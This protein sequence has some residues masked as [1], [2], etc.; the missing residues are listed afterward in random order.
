MV[1]NEGAASPS[2][3]EGG[4]GVS[5][6]GD[7]SG[8]P[9]NVSSPGAGP[10]A[11]QNPPA[12]SLEEPAPAVD[13]DASEESGAGPYRVTA[14]DLGR[15]AVGAVTVV[16]A[17][18]GLVLGIRA[19]LYAGREDQRAEKAEQ[20]AAAEE[21]RSKEDREKAY[22][23][24]VDFYRMGSGVIV[25][26]GSS[27]VMTMRLTLPANKVSWDLDLLQPCK[28]I[29]VQNKA[30]LHS[31]AVEQPSVSLAEGDLAQLRLEFM[32][33]ES[34]AWIRHSGGALAR[35]DA[36]VPSRR[37]NLVSSE[38]WNVSAQDSPQCDGS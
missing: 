18:V 13:P 4:A 22:A 34:K 11:A 19:E 36:W 20:R 16:A 32:D 35:M 38:E 5:G 25:V 37:P 27:R 23:N 29:A 2:E 8:T 28:Q 7:G 3:S 31:M 24:L 14:L 12:P 9:E 26:N 30:L 10:V 6:G 33:P 1:Q 15:F 17:L 21:L